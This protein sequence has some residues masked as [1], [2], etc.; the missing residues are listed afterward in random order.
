M[1]ASRF[2]DVGGLRLHYLDHDGDGPVLVLTHGL[3]ANAHFFDGL[4][5]AGLAPAL[6]VLS[7]DLRGR[8]LSD[9]P[10]RGYSM[11]EHAAD[12]IGAL[13]VLGL[14]RV[15]LGGHSFG[16]L[17]TF[18]L[19]AKAPERIERAL[20]LDVPAEVDTGVLDQIGPSLARLDSTYSSHAAYLEFVRALPYFADGGWDD[21]VAAFYEAELEESPGGGVR[22][23]CRPE[24]IRLAVEGTLELDWPAIADCVECPTLLLRTIDPFGPK[25]SAPIMSR[26]GALRTLG[27]LRDGRLLEVPGNHITFAF[28]SRAAPVAAELLAFAVETGD[29]VAP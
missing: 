24:H 5:A 19:A 9:K 8:G 25:G 29:R 28:G 22:S 21:S 11:A 23:R 12:L 15:L 20:V 17:L 27:R 7:F 10:A 18:Y 3:S 13:D 16:G 1:S 6:R 4:V 26:D 14:E 2:V